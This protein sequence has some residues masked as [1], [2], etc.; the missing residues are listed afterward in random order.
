M[1]ISIICNRPLWCAYLFAA[2]E[3]GTDCTP[4]G[5]QAG[6]HEAKNG[7]VVKAQP[8]MRS[9]V[10]GVIQG[11]QALLTCHYRCPSCRVCGSF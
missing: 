5:S 3:L 7:T 8:A 6:S 1:R 2:L 11:G 9:P 4:A 10:N